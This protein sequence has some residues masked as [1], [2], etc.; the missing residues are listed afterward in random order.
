MAD[1]DEVA[2]G[3]DPCDGA[4]YSVLMRHADTDGERVRG[5]LDQARDPALPVAP[6]TEA[7]FWCAGRE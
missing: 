6:P 5:T 7:S 4:A 1:G 3:T 2:S